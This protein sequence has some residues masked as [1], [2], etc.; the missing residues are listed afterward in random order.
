MEKLL[1]LRR[2]CGPAPGSWIKRIAALPNANRFQF[3]T[4]GNLRRGSLA[5]HDGF[6]TTVAQLLETSRPRRRRA[7]S[8]AR[9]TMED[10]S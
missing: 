8:Q 5:W 1:D 7:D 2:D 6:G 9:G 10:F 4:L 3:N